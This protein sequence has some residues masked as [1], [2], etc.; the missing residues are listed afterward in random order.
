MN[1]TVLL[2]ISKW[3]T[4]SMLV[5]NEMSHSNFVGYFGGNG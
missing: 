1:I 2:A 3:I 5:S 4:I